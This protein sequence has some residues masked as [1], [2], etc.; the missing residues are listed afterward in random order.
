M[1]SIIVTGRTGNLGKA[2]AD[3]FFNEGYNVAG[4]VLHD[5]PAIQ[6]VN[7]V[8]NESYVVDLAD[9]KKATEFVS[10]VTKKFNKIDIAVLTAGGFVMGDI[11]HT[12][13]ADISKQFFL[14]FQTTYNM[15]R[16]VFLQ[17]IRQNQGHL[18]LTGSV[19]GAD[20]KKSKG[21]IAYGLSKSLIF[22]LAELLNEEAT[23][24]GKNVKVSVIVPS[25]IDT[26]QNRAAMPDADFSKWTSPEKIA[27]IVYSYA[28]GDSAFV[29]VF[30]V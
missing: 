2:I 24:A 3:K 19:P 11:E 13:M 6:E 29:P 12:G 20:M 21:K 22:R 30:F 14:N 25:T 1:K 10:S 9:E 27:D 17:M 15:A 28:A 26:P 18:F 8:I 7:Q 23:A 16:P 5:V 4:T